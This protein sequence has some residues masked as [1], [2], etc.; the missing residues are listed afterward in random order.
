MDFS[1]NNKKEK[2]DL[3]VILSFSEFSSQAYVTNH[4]SEVTSSD[5]QPTYQTRLSVSLPVSPYMRVYL[6]EE[7]VN[8][9]KVCRTLTIEKK[10]T[11][12]TR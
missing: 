2:S 8:V 5:L 10:K 4:S 7:E 9:G 1:H 11:L 3:S 12:E 6:G